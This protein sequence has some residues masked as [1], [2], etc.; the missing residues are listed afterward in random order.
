VWLQGAGGWL[1]ISGRL[2]GRRKQKG[3]HDNVAPEGYLA[4][5]RFDRHA[6][7]FHGVLFQLADTFR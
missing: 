3:R 1:G 4:V 7:F 6:Q 5:L 2:G